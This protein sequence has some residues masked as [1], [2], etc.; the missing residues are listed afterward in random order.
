MR[1]F[2]LFIMKYIIIMKIKLL[3]REVTGSIPGKPKRSYKALLVR[4][5]GEG[6]DG[7][8][9]AHIHNIAPLSK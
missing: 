4:P 8:N 1:S 6:S 5:F 9:I 2:L 7:D 3:V